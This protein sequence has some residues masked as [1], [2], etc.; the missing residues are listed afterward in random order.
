MTRESP[1]TLILTQLPLGE[2]DH[3]T[4]SGERTTSVSAEVLGSAIGRV[5][6]AAL[7]SATIWALV[8]V[9]N[10]ALPLAGFEFVGAKGWPT[11]NWIYAAIGVVGSS[12]LAY[13]AGRARSTRR[14]TA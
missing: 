7:I 5:R 10:V 8:L 12:G 1:D 4:S 11:P 13:A 6:I 2:Q 3:S 9:F 14:A